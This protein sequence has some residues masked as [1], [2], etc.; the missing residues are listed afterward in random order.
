MTAVWAVALCILMKPLNSVAAILPLKIKGGNKD[1]DR[2]E[3]R[4]NTKN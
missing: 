4:N 2:K 1:A 3:N